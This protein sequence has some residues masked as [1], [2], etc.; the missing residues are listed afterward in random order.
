MR[1]W[2]RDGR[3]FRFR[4][5]GCREVA[6]SGCVIVGR[7]K[8]RTRNP[9]QHLF[10]E[11]LLYFSGRARV[12]RCRPP[13]G[14]LDRRA[15]P[16]HV[17][18]STGGRVGIK[19]LKTIFENCKPREEVLRGELR[20]QQFAA[21]L[22]NV[23]R[24]GADEVYGDPTKFFANTFP[25][26][27]LKALLTEAL[28]RLSGIKPANAPIIR[29]ETSFGGGKTH[30][31]ISLLHLCRGGVAPKATD[32]FVSR[33]L[34]PA[35]AVKKIAGI[36]GPDMDVANGIDH[37]SVRTF[38]V[39]GEIAYQIAGK[40][41]YEIVRKSDEQRHVTRNAG[42]G[43]IDRRRPRTDHD[44]RDRCLPSSRKRHDGG[45]H[46]HGG[47]DGRVSDVVDQIRL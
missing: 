9:F 19:P 25:T 42:L 26:G 22:T 37:E 24:G 11:H 21:S 44:R 35:T 38:S 29:L 3:P 40:S 12:P 14:R 1:R 34:L 4:C 33:D 39:W 27:G 41:G 6:T 2:L 23:L 10:S 13:P 43:K 31:L 15:P 16:T 47:A 8:S 46:Q 17:R 30:N 20:E 32:R 28:G 36:V 18:D 7:R 45:L 5:S